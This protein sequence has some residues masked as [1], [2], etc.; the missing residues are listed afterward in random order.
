MDAN[1]PRMFINRELSWLAFNARVLAEAREPALPPYERLKFLAIAASN[2]DEFFM[3]RVAGI[4][5]Q[6]ASGVTATE[7]DGL[8]P[9]E[10]QAITARVR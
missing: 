3:V 4:K 5:Q 6:M 2:L 7:A 10:L 1:D 9:T 8:S